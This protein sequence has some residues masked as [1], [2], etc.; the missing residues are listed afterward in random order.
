MGYR[1]PKSLKR[2]DNETKVAWG[3]RQSDSISDLFWDQPDIQLLVAACIYH[4]HQAPDLPFWGFLVQTERWHKH[5]LVRQTLLKNLAENKKHLVISE[6]HCDIIRQGLLFCR[7]MRFPVTQ[8]LIT[9]ITNSVTWPYPR[10]TLASATQ[11]RGRNS[12]N[13]IWI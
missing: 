6:T 9:R 13:S 1:R 4:L 12:A 5:V 2:N 7:F 3:R 11:L 8:R 10:W